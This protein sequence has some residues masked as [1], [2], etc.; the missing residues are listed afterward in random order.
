MGQPIFSGQ[1]MPEYH[2]GVLVVKIR[3]S[4]NLRA[5]F[6]AATASSTVLESQG[7]SALSTFERAGLI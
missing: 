1:Q 2:Q 4:S 6:S 3:S 7:M 5:T